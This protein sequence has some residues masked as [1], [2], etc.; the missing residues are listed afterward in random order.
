[1]NRDVYVTRDTIRVG[2][3]VYPAHIGIRKFKGCVEY[4]AA[5][6]AIEPTL[7]FG[8]LGRAMS[9]SLKDCKYIYGFIPKAGEAWLIE[10]GKKTKVDIDF[11]D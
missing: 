7:W 1:M 4:G 10:G 9:L 8:I 6:E 11:T 3:A 5:N 2:V